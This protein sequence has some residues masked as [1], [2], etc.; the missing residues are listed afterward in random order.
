MIFDIKIDSG[1][2]LKI[3]ALPVGFI[4]CWVY[5]VWVDTDKSRE[6]DNF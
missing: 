1:S 2:Y 6:G 4:C 3:K 5:W